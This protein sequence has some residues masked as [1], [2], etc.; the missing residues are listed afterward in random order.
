MVRGPISNLTNIRFHQGVCDWGVAGW[1]RVAERKGP[2]R[3][4]NTNPKLGAKTGLN[5]VI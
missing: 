2:A 4:Q 5:W 1:L 3:E